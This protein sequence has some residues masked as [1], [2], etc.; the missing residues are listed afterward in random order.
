MAYTVYTGHSD[1]PQ[2]IYC[3]LTTCVNLVKPAPFHG[4]GCGTDPL[5]CCGREYIQ[6]AQSSRFRNT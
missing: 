2:A 3:L 1:R 4:G 5:E 6:Y